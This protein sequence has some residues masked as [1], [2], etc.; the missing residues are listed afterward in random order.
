MLEIRKSRF[1]GVSTIFYQC[2]FMI[3][4]Q[5]LMLFF[6]FVFFFLGIVSWKEDALLLNG[7]ASFVSEYGVPHMGGGIDFDRR[8]GPHCRKP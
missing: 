6:F 5:V 1:C 8:G 3:E 2:Y 7:R 4:T